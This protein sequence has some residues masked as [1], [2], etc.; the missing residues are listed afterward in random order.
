VLEVSNGIDL[1]TAIGAALTSIAN[2]GP[3]FGEVGI[4]GNFSHL[5][6]V[7]KVFLSF[8]MILGRLELFTLL[9]LFSTATWR[10]F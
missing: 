8:L 1:E 4:W 2:V 3:G 6:G 7:T 9:A 10:R 5:T